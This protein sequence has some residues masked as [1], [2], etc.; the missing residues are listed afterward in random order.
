M[1]K[2]SSQDGQWI[3]ATRSERRRRGSF[4]TAQRRRRRRR[5][6][7]RLSHSV[8]HF[9]KCWISVREGRRVTNEYALS[10]VYEGH[11]GK[12]LDIVPIHA[13]MH[14][15]LGFITSPRLG[16]YEVKKLR[17]LPAAGWRTQL[18][19]SYSRNQWEVINPSPI[20]VTVVG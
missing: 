1:P 20:Q 8:T 14:A 15:G 7:C 3:G 16:E 9:S 6:Q 19:D 17:S 4:E 5:Q 10:M 13:H 2:K 11:S 12:L 18:F